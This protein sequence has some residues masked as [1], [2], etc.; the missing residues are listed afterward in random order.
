MVSPS[1]QLRGGEEDERRRWAPGSTNSAEKA[2]RVGKGGGGVK[3]RVSVTSRR[4]T[5]VRVALPPNDSARSP[6]WTTT[7]S[8]PCAAGGGRAGGRLAAM[9]E[10]LPPEMLSY[11]LSFLPLSDQKEASLVNRAWYY[12]AQI[13][14]R[15]IDVRYN[16]PVTAASLSSIKRLS[17]RHVSCVSLINVDGSS[18][19]NSVLQSISYY[20]G[21]HLQSL[22]LGGGS[23][24]EASFVRLIISCPGLQ[25]LDLSGCNSLFMSGK[26][27]DQPETV[28]QVQKALANLRDLNLSGL[29]HLA[30]SSFNRLSSCTP[31]L[32]RLSLARCHIT[33][34]PHRSRSAQPGSSAILSFPNI[35]HFLKERASHLVALDL[36]GTNLTP[37]ALHALGQVVGLHLRELVLRGCRDISTEA[38]AVLC[39]Q[40]RDLTSLDL[41]GCSELADGALLVVSRGL[42]SLQHLRLEKLQQLTDSGFSSLHWLR[43]LRSLDLAECCRVSGRELAKAL[44]FPRGP[45]PRLASLRLAYCSLLKDASV[46]SL[47]QGLGSS[48]KV[49]DLSSCMSL[50]NSSLLAISANLPQLTVLRL[51]W[52]KEITDSGLLG[53]ADPGEE[54]RGKKL[55]KNFGDMGFFL[56]Q[57]PPEPLAPL[58]S[59]SQETPNKQLTPSLLLLRALQ[60]LDLT[61]CS[62]LTDNSLAKVL[63]FPRLRQ[64]SL[65][66]IL[67]FSDVGLV[68]VAQGCPSL[69]HL[70]L[71]H[72]GRLSD[73]GWARAASFWRRLQHL[74][75]SNCNQLTEQTLATIRQACQQLKVLDVSMSQGI[76]MAAVEH[77]QAQLP[78]VT[79][80]QSRFVGGA[81]L[82]MTL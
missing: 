22:S 9:A 23:L 49:L 18:D 40:Q 71:S 63:K 41:S 17:R 62:K 75:L 28:Q 68:A 50:T 64:L 29:R 51:A 67:E 24:T 16:I 3:G 57:L 2:L 44:E 73:G 35:L 70:A 6:H 15:E 7:S 55:N 43:E 39:R 11:I 32:E 81:D 27:L 25:V 53:L 76:S 77:F 72:C 69:E 12:A 66:L 21:P 47:A 4:A 59:P 8:G 74:N 45:P 82:A 65:S 14:L 30:D 52:C 13:A 33:F 46:I 34:D 5:E 80:V 38:V 36:S 58:E 78:Q 20:L 48:L 10:S 19:A 56:P 42:Q 37:T 26:L 61:A 1:R 79:C 31:K 54:D 60:E